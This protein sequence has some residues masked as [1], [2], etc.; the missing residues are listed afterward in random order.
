MTDVRLPFGIPLADAAAAGLP[1]GLFRKFRST[2]CNGVIR[3]R[4]CIKIWRIVSLIERI[5]ELR[6]AF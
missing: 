3:S 6:I 1:A 5:A 4:F 2:A